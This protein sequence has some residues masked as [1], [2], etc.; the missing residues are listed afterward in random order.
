VPDW[1]RALDAD[2][3]TARC[4]HVALEGVRDRGW[5]H[6]IQRL[7]VLG[8]HALQRGYRPAELSDWFREAFVVGFEWVVPPTVTGMSHYADGG[9]LATKPQR[10]QAAHRAHVRP[11]PRC[12]FDPANPANACRSR[13]VLGVDP[14]PP[15]DAGSHHRTARAVARMDRRL[16]I[17]TPWWSREPAAN[18]SSQSRRSCTRGSLR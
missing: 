7:M 13:R 2:A 5:T 3:V 11:L 1:W 16:P 8:N 14:P 15:A 12:A 18:P 4:L 10:G 6:H 9:L 17:S